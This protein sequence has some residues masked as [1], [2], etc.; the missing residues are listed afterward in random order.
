MVPY[1]EGPSVVSIM[2]W[3]GVSGAG[4]RGLPRYRCRS[5][6][7]GSSS[8]VTREYAVPDLPILHRRSACK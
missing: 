1:N 4:S 5:S 8:R 2:P 3:P 6:R 7:Y